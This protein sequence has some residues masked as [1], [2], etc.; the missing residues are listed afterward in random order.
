M[1]RTEKK[2]ISLIKNE[3]LNKAQLLQKLKE[4]QIGLNEYA[5]TLFNSDL[6]Q[7]SLLSSEVNLIELSMSE[8]GLKNGGNFEDIKKHLKALNLSH[9]PLEIAIYV[10][11]KFK[12]QL[13]SDEKK[14]NKTPPGSITFFSKPLS[15]EDD[16]PKGFYIKNTNG[17]LWL[18]G[19]ICSEDYIWEAN[20]RM[21]FKVNKK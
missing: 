16:F 17:T 19:Y 6:F 8:I 2:D 18:R 5:H 13:E 7:P 21:I 20:D 15:E 1:D 3:G 14:S 10:R 9:C 4:A 11:L 12:D